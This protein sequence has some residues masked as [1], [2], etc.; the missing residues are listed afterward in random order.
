M[1]V[2][3][4]LNFPKA[5]HMTSGASQTLPPSLLHQKNAPY[6]NSSAVQHSTH[7]ERAAEMHPVDA[8]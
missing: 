8:L 5:H 7:A 6:Y 3:S 2:F 1:V 4:P